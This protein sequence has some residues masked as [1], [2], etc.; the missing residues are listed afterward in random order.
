[1]PSRSAFSCIHQFDRAPPPATVHR[2][3]G[4]PAARNAAIASRSS[5]AMPSIVAFTSST[6]DVARVTPRIAPAA[7]GVARHGAGAPERWGTTSAAA[8]PVPE[9]SSDRSSPRS[10]TPLVASAQSSA[11]VP[12]GLRAHNPMPGSLGWGVTAS[13]NRAASRRRGW[14]TGATTDSHVPAATSAS[15]SSTA[16]APTAAHEPSQLPT[17]N[18]QAAGRPSSRAAAGRTRPASVPQG[19]TS[20]RMRRSMPSA[21]TR[22]FDQSSVARSK[23]RKPAASAGSTMGRPDSFNEISSCQPR[24]HRARTS[25]RGWVSRHQRSRLVGSMWSGT[26]P[27]ARTHLSADSRMIP[28]ACTRGRRASAVRRHIPSAVPS[29]RAGKLSR[30]DAETASAAGGSSRRA[31]FAA[32][33]RTA[34]TTAPQTSFPSL[35]HSPGAGCSD[36]AGSLDRASSVPVSR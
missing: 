35:S 27:H 19:T 3:I 23:I 14:E 13:R 1:M 33:R 7:C 16:A 10:R 4:L 31:G 17:T 11:L 30:P 15:P 18:R 25:V 28:V 12:L 34:L 32:S 6:G 24:N 2:T 20:G 21:A 22:S 8:G 36:G 29:A 26:C 5:S 9:S